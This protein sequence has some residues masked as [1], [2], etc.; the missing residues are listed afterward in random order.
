MHF[1]AS[2]ELECQVWV[3]AISA[4]PGVNWAGRPGWE[5]KGGVTADTQRLVESELQ[6]SHY[7]CHLACPHSMRLNEVRT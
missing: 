2:T 5:R 1:Q 7:T 3:N 4:I 6:A